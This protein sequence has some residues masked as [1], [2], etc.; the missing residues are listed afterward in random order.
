MKKI[1]ILLSATKTLPSRLI[2]TIMKG[3]YTHASIA[4]EPRSDKLYSFARRTLNNPLNAGFIIED[5][6][7]FVY[8]RYENCPC[9]VYSVEVS[10]EAYEKAKNIVG[11]FVENKKVLN[12]NFLGLLPA[13]LGIKFERKKNFTCSQFVASVLHYSGAVELPKHPSLMM[14]NDFPKLEGVKL[15]YTGTIKNCFLESHRKESALKN[16]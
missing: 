7:K 2:H 16:S 4:L 1:Y 5:L 3:G 6:H 10:D 13:K 8:S 12:Y 11:K 14:P 15:I 9:A